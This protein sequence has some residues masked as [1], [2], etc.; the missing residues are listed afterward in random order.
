MKILAIYF[1]LSLHVPFLCQSLETLKKEII[2]CKNDTQRVNLLNTLAWNLKESNSDSSVLLS[3]NAKKISESINWTKGNARS[4]HQLGVFNYYKGDNNSA[5]Q[6]YMKAKSLWN[7]LIT[8]N[9]FT[10]SIHAKSG[11]AK[12]LGNMGIIYQSIGKYDSAIN[13][14]NDALHI[15]QELNDKAGMVRDQINIGTLYKDQSDFS[16]AIEFYYRALKLA[17]DLKL[18]EMQANIL[19]NIGVLYENQ[20]DHKRALDYLLSSFKMAEQLE[21][22]KLIAN[23]L[24]N[25]GNVYMAKGEY[26]RAL[27]Y[28]KKALLK[29]EE[30]S[31][32]VGMASHIGNIAN[33]YGLQA[34]NAQNDPETYI[35]LNEL[36]LINYEKALQ[37]NRQLHDKNGEATNILNIGLLHLR[38][39]NYSLAEKFII[40]S[41]H[42]SKEQGALGLIMICELNLSDLFV[43]RNDYDK[44]LMHYKNYITTRDIISNEENN[45]RQVK[46]ELNFEFEKKQAVLNEKQ[47]KARA[48]A[49]EKDNFN[50]IVI[51]SVVMG[52]LIVSLFLLW[53][54]R[55]LKITKKQKLIIEG[56]QKEILDSIRYAK[57]IQTSLLPTSIYIEKAMNQRKLN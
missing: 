39:R 20:Q 6:H 31:D 8:S 50:K 9:D 36:S 45:K 12:T 28:H 51:L 19:S 22:H 37:L 56:K 44:A 41:L 26:Q 57:R 42:M 10:L 1:C 14:Y 5:L 34:K 17:Q 15:N 18:L 33:V 3:T 29:A 38:T 47:E 48:L 24:G 27:I 30:I 13:Y 54:F 4:E 11:I 53:I 49:K 32:L 21:M 55:S 25:L 43:L 35:K 40:E 23:N 52:I 2:Q 7:E 16:K 46:A